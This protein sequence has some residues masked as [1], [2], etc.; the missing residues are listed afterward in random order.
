LGSNGFEWDR[1]NTNEETARTLIDSLEEAGYLPDSVL[2]L[3]R[4]RLKPYQGCLSFKLDWLLGKNL[5]ALSS[6]QKRDT[7]TGVLSLKPGT[8]R[9]VN[10]GPDRISD[11]L[12]IYADIDLA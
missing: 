4:G 10:S 5:R 3:F 6:G 1:L 11:H 7:L 8:V 12:P 2:R 9:M